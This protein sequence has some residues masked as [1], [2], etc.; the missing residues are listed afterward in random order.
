MRPGPT[1]IPVEI[2]G[3][4]QVGI[5]RYVGQSAAAVI[6]RAGEVATGYPS[7]DSLKDYQAAEG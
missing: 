1:A 7:R 6:Q 2:P 3:I 5:A 4:D